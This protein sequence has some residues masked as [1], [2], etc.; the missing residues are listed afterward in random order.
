MRRSGVPSHR[1]LVLGGVLTCIGLI[2]ALAPG[3]AS[4]AGGYAA[5]DLGTLGG[6]DAEAAAINDSGQV[7]GFSY[8][9]GDDQRAFSWTQG[10]GMVNLGTLGGYSSALAVNDSGA[11]VGNSFDSSD[12][13]GH[14]FFWTQA[15]GM[16]DVGTRS[17]SNNSDATDLNNSGQV[18]GQSGARP[19]SWTQAGGLIELGSLGGGTGFAQAVNNSGQ[20]VGDSFTSGGERHAFLW[21]QAGGMVDLGTLGGSYSLALDINDSGQVVGYS[22]T[23]S[24]DYHPFSWTQAGGMVDLGTLGGVANGIASHVSDSGQ[25]VGRL[26]WVGVGSEPRGFSWTQAGGM[27]DLGA[28]GG[29]LTSSIPRG[30]S[31]SGQVVGYSDTPSGSVHRGFSWTQ[32][33][34]LIDLGTLLS[35]D[36]STASDV[37]DSGQIVGS[38]TTNSA[39]DATA[40]LW[41]AA[42]DPPS[43]T[44]NAAD[45]EV[46]AAGCTE[47]HCS[48]REA[49]NRANSEPGADTIDFDIAPSGLQTITPASPL[50]EIT[51]PVTIDATTQPGYVDK[52]IIELDGSTAGAAS[53]LKIAPAGGGSTVRGF[54]INRFAENGIL[55]GSVSGNEGSSDNLVAGNFI[56]TNA[57][58]TADQGNALHGVLIADQDATGNRIGGTTAADRNVISGNDSIGVVIEGPS[59]GPAAG[60]VGEN[61]VEGNYIGTD[62]SG[63][64][65]LGNG[66]YGVVIQDGFDNTIGGTAPGAGNLI[67]SNR[68]GI[69]ISN[70]TS[71]G[72]VVA[73]NLIGTNAA[74]GGA[75]PNSQHGVDMAFTPPDNTIGGSGAGAGNTIANNGRSG[76]LVER[77]SSGVEISSNS[78]HSN[79]ELGI[80]LQ[81]STS[82]GISGDGVSANDTGDPDTG[83]N[84]LQNFPLLE[85]A[86]SGG[87]QTNLAGTLNSQPSLTGKTYRLD[88]FA[89]PSCDSSGNGEGKTFLGSEEVSTDPGGDASF[90]VTLPSGT[91]VGDTIAATATDTAVGN[92]SEFSAC[93]EVA[94]PSGDTPPT[95]VDDEQTVDEDSGATEIDV[96]ANDTDPDGGPKAIDQASDPDHGTVQVTGGGSVSP[97]SPTPTTATTAPRP[98][99][100]PTPWPRATRRRRC[101]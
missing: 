72:N 39:G 21:T 51:D 62:L 14:A 38:A 1:R 41:E 75:L 89:S 19:F 49:I 85:S 3:A 66:H 12:G 27:V 55:I 50:P 30:I 94:E 4:G 97:T 73:G 42:A 54:A 16:I 48:L 23:S 60:T 43:F 15:G 31:D 11:V 2:G 67:S 47:S 92:T 24:G 78:I 8:T 26:Y 100:S 53:G 63:S 76:V 33:G 10:G 80:D 25:V 99:T 64:S 20:V 79:A 58:G 68:G 28:L 29:G 36:R 90:N 18:V 45:D 44:V 96:L 86:A 95:A 87:G 7:V 56:G 59:G 35:G 81:S 88:F 9:S 77:T 91:A 65:A 32:A 57:A 46:D 74:G 34:G 83:G 22:E 98:T 82:S 93:E 6:P 40:L 37:N 71:T 52:P 101:G 61:V 84:E 5:T 13:A 69:R 17:G 70:S